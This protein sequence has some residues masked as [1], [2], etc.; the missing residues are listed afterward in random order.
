MFSDIRVSAVGGGEASEEVDWHSELQQRQKSPLVPSKATKITK[1]YFE[2]T[3]AYEDSSVYDLGSLAPGTKIPGPALILDA[4][5]TIIIFPE[6]TATILKDIIY[7]DVGLGP[8]SA[9][10][11]KAVDPI[12]L[13]IFGNRCVSPLRALLRLRRFMAIAEQMGRV[14][15]KCATSLQIKERLDFSCAIFS[16][17]GSLVANAPHVP[18]HLGSMQY[19]VRG[20]ADLHRG[21]LRPGDV[22]VSNHPTMGGTHLPDITVICPVFNILDGVNEV[23][24]YVAARAHHNE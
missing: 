8:R 24:F 12:A 18:V 3:S 4:T 14:L 5:Q 16:A 6:N 1:I 19:A 22:L 20:Q 21:K 2:E 15:Q 10:E 13:S 9:L 23:V 7:I 17:D 11:V